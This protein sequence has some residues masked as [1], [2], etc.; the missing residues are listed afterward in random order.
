MLVLGVGAAG[1]GEHDAQSK[2]KS[3]RLTM[4]VGGDLAD[5]YW[6][7]RPWRRRVV[8][9]LPVVASWKRWGRR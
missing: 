8:V 3:D 9:L 4:K 1:D 5:D 7:C 2:G 6:Y